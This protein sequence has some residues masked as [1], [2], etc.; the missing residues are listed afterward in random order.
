MTGA[1]CGGGGRWP[2]PACFDCY[3][4]WAQWRRLAVTS[5]GWDVSPCDDCPPAYAAEMRAQR[6]CE[7][8]EVRVLYRQNRRPA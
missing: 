3:E 6:R 7:E 4:G 2:F 5:K 1:Q 8:A